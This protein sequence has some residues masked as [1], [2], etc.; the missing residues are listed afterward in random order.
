[1]Q[2]RYFC[3]G[4][5]VYLFVLN[6]TSFPPFLWTADRYLTD[7]VIEGVVRFAYN[8]RLDQLAW[9]APQ[10]LNCSVRSAPTPTA[11]PN[12][13]PLSNTSHISALHGHRPHDRITSPARV[14]AAPGAQAAEGARGGAYVTNLSTE[15]HLPAVRVLARA[16][17]YRHPSLPSRPITPIPALRPQLLRR[18]ERRR[19]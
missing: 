4:M 5:E 19:E 7:W 6:D 17:E 13:T 11:G 14:A 10:A 9:H 15:D 2:P 12:A 18:A 3:H 1:M 8:K 16:R